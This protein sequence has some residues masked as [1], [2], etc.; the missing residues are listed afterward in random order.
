S[1]TVPFTSPAVAMSTFWPAGVP[2]G[3]VG[4]ADL[5][6]VDWPPPQATDANRAIPSALI[7]TFRRR[8]DLSPRRIILYRPAVEVPAPP[9]RSFRST[10]SCTQRA[11][12]DSTGS[13]GCPV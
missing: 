10:R 9:S 3:A 5:F 8:I 2:A 13:P 6:E 4:S 1:V 7:Q 11:S 12:H